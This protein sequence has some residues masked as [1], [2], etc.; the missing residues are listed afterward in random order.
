[1]IF[2]TVWI[3]AA[4]AILPGGAYF[5]RCLLGAKRGPLIVAVTSAYV[6][7]CGLA[8]WW[9]GEGWQGWAGAAGMLV[10]YALAV[11]LILGLGRSRVP[12]AA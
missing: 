7:L 9:L 3:V 2:A 1:M 11:A 10:P 5:G 6:V 4:W 12:P 8:I